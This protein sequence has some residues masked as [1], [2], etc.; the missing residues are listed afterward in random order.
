MYAGAGSFV[1]D[2]A[3]EGRRNATAQRFLVANDRLDDALQSAQRNR[4]AWRSGRGKSFGAAPPA[5]LELPFHHD[6][7][8]FH[9]VERGQGR[10]EPYEGLIKDI[11]N[12]PLKLVPATAFWTRP[13]AEP[14]L[15][16]AG[17]RCGAE[18]NR[19]SC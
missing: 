6:I 10:Y 12:P 4:S 15:A 19:R 9:S 11:V 16:G 7:R 3:A 1:A 18:T 13:F 8:P 14:R 5:G 17:A 2:T